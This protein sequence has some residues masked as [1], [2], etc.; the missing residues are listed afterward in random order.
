MKLKHFFVIFLFAA[1]LCSQ[2]RKHASDQ[3]P[4]ATQ[5]GAGTLGFTINGKV[6]KANFPDAFATY[7]HENFPYPYGNGYFLTVGT[8]VSAWGIGLL[9]DSLQVFEGNTYLL[10]NSI[11]SKGKAYAAYISNNKTYYTQPYLSGELSITKLDIFNKIIS[12]TF[13]L[14]AIDTLSNATVQIRDGRFDL[15]YTE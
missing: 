15:H 2:C 9:T 8:N 12:G 6:Y 10:N 5:T 7:I 14:D 3:L 13:W 4:P 1:L 11:S